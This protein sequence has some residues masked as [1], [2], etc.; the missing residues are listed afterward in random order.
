MRPRVLRLLIV[1][2]TVNIL[3]TGCAAYWARFSA[4]LLQQSKIVVKENDFEMV[5]TGLTGT[6]SVWH[7]FG[8]IPLG[9]ERL[10]SRA[11]GE[12]YSKV[13]PQATGESA[14]LINWTDDETIL[15]IPFP[16]YSILTYK[17]VLLRADLM[18]F[19]K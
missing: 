9:D 14:Q 10:Y 8:F 5:E 19:T 11:M 15:C 6:A 7:L 1:L 17:K 4:P 3:G 2:L 18:K 16:G 13:A 12:L